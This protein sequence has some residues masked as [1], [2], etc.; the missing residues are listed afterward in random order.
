MPLVRGEPGELSVAALEGGLSSLSDSPTGA[1]EL[2]PAWAL[3]YASR[4]LVR[5]VISCMSGGRRVS[6][7][8]HS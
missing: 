5:R 3:V 1:M 8:L 7:S 4:S 6:V 2:L